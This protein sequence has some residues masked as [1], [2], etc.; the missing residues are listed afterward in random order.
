MRLGI[1]RRRRDDDHFPAGQDL[2]GRLGRPDEPGSGAAAS[3]GAVPSA[4]APPSAG[5][6]DG[7]PDGRPLPV[8]DE[9]T[10]DVVTATKRRPLYHR[11]LR[12]RHIA[13]TAWQRAAFADA[14]FAVAVVLVLADVLGPRDAPVLRRQVG[15]AAVCLYVAVV[16]MTFVFFYPVLTGQPLTHAEWL[17]RMW[18]PSWF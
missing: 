6:V 8:I 4:G 9:P 10:A 2:P 13:P 15:L 1:R 17:Q 3:G 11:L 12:L 14:P 7:G 18:F 5:T 16:A